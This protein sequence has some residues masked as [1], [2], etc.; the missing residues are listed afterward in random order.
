MGVVEGAWTWLTTGANWAGENG[1]T[2]RLGE[3]LYVSG[4]ALLVASALAL[5]VALYL[6]HIG[7]GGALAVN[8]SNVGRAVPVFAVLALFMVTPLRNS[9][10]LP[11]VIALV[12]FAVPP[13]LTNAYVGMRQVDRS[14][15]EAARGMGMSGGQLFLR[16]ELPLAYP[17]IMTGLRSAAV[18]VVATASIAAMVG[19]GGL[20]R[21]ITAGFN[22]YDTAQVFAGAVLVALLAL[23]VEG[24]LV[25][26]DRLLSPLRRRRTA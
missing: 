17:M 24:A 23:V 11:T 21:I 12:L 13:L 14:V 16:V 6:G 18:Q 15:I 9:G 8:L 19:L 2:H 26:L 7:K 1:A 10:Y 5:P 20:G 3:H 4:V 25:A 22:T